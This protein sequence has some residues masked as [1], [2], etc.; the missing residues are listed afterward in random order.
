MTRR[1]VCICLTIYA[2]SGAPIDT[3]EIP[4]GKRAR[5]TPRRIKKW[6]QR[7]QT[8]GRVTR[9]NVF[10]N[11]RSQK[12]EAMRL[13]DTITEGQIGIYASAFGGVFYGY[14]IKYANKPA[15][16]EEPTGGDA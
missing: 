8:I 13:A 16:F 5:W 7:W 10:E 3:I 4:T 6:A 2:P 9:H 11:R 15:Y 14:A 1:K 12:A